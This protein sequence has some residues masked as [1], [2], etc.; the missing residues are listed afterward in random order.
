MRILGRIKNQIANKW[1]RWRIN[2][3]LKLRRLAAREG[4][5]VTFTVVYRDGSIPREVALRRSFLTA[6][7]AAD[8]LCGVLS[9]GLSRV[10]IG[11]ISSGTITLGFN[12]GQIALILGALADLSPV[13]PKYAQDKIAQVIEENRAHNWGGVRRGADA[14]KKVLEAARAE[15]SPV[16]TS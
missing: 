12:F 5:G 7:T 15:N 11:T 8:I 3:W 14:A 2:R 13:L 1:D 9:G 16:V 4:S 10:G 6:E